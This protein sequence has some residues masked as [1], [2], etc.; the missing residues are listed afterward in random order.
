L[1]LNIV[2][3]PPEAKP[4][5]IQVNKNENYF[6]TYLK[7]YLLR[8]SC[9]YLRVYNFTK[10]LLQLL[11]IK[12]TYWPDFRF[13]RILLKQL[14]LYPVHSPHTVQIMQTECFQLCFPG[15]QISSLGLFSSQSSSIVP[16]S[17]ATLFW[18]TGSIL[19]T[20]E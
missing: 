17:L 10:L 12:L 19:V 3:A 20:S 1:F 15:L 14:M 13:D 8:L 18:L 6:I 11:F 2:A 16:C 7:Y 5:L 9:L 4:K